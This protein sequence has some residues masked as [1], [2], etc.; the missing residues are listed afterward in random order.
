MRHVLFATTAGETPAAYLAFF[1]LY[2]IHWKNVMRP[3]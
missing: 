3:F 2:P 1:A